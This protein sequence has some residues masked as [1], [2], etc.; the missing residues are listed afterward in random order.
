MTVTFTV[1]AA[2]L[3]AD[4]D[5]VV[6]PVRATVTDPNAPAGQQ[7]VTDELTITIMPPADTTPA[8]DVSF[9][10]DLALTTGMAVNL[11][12]PAATGGNG[13]L[14]YSLTPAIAGLTL[15]PT[16]RV[17]SGTP[18]SLAESTHT[19][20]VTDEDSDAASITFDLVVEMGAPPDTTPAF[21][22]SS[23]PDL[24]L[25][26]GTAVNMTLPAATG[27]NGALTYSLAPAIAGLTLNPTTRV[28]S[29]TPT[30]IAESTHTYTVTD[31]DSDTASL[32]FD[33]VV[34]MGG[35][36][37]VRPVFFQVASSTFNNYDEGG[38]A[39]GGPTTFFA[40]AGTETVVLTLTGADASFFSITQ[41]GALSFN[42]APDF[43]MPRG[44]APSGSNTNTYRVTVLA[45]A[46]PGGLT[47]GQ[48][49]EVRVVDVDEVVD[50]APSFSVTSIAAQNYLTGTAVNFTFPAA[51]GG[52]TPYTYTLTRSDG[53]AVDLPG[54]TFNAAANPPTLTGTPTA[55]RGLRGHF[56]TVH[57]SDANMA[58]GDRARLSFNIVVRAPTPTRLTL[59]IDPTMVT[60]SA[61][62]TTITATVTFVGG[63]YTRSRIV[64][65][66]LQDGTALEGPDFPPLPFT[67]LTIPANTASGTLMF[68]FTATADGIAEAGG[69][70]AKIFAALRDTSNAGYDGSLALVNANLTIN[71]PP[72]ID[73]APAFAAGAS[74]DDQSY[75]T[76]LAITPLTLPAVATPG[77]GATTYTL[78][79][80]IAGLTLN[81]TSRVL[82]GTPTTAATVREY[83]YTATDTDD[84][85]DTLTFNITVVA[86]TAPSFGTETITDQIFTV[87]TP[88][89]LTLPLATGGNNGITYSLTAPPTGLIFTPS[90]RALSGTPTAAFVATDLT[91]SAIDGD[92]NT[93]PSDRADITFSIT[94][95][96]P[97]V[98]ATGLTVTVRRNPGGV[99]T[100]ALEGSTTPTAVIATPTPAGSVFAADQ[101]V[102]FT[103]TPASPASRPDSPDDP[104]VA[105]NNIAPSTVAFAVGSAEARRT[106]SLRPTDDA[107]DHADFPLT[108][109]ATAQPSGISGT[110]TVTLIDN[111][112]RIITTAATATV[113]AAATTTYDVTLSEQ[114]PTGVAV[115]VASQGAGTATV[116]PATLTFTV[117]D[118]NMAQTVTVTGV[119]A[120]STTIRHTAPDASG[121][122]YV[123]NDVDVT[124]TAAPVAPVFTNADD[125][126]SPILTPENRAAVGADGYFAATGTGTVTYALTGADMARFTLSA[127]G[128]LTF[129]DAPDFE[130]P[131]GMAPATGNTNDYALTITATNSVGMTDATV[132]VS[133]TDVN[134]APVVATIT[135]SAFTEY[136]PGTF[137]ITVTDV[138]DGQTLTFALSAPNHGATLTGNTFT[139]TPGEDDG[140]V[141]RTFS[142]TVTDSGSPPQ[143]GHR[144]LR[145]HRNGTGE[146]RPDRRDH[147]RRRQ[148]HVGDQSGHP[149]PVRSRDRPR[150]RH[151]A[152]LHLEFGRHRR[153]LLPRHRHQHHLD[154]ADRHVRDPG[155]PDGHRERRRRHHADD[156]HGHAECDGESDV[157]GGHHPGPRRR[158]PPGL[159]RRPDGCVDP[160]G[161]HRRHRPLH[162]HPG[163]AGRLA[164][165][166]AHRR[167]Y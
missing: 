7:T 110:A 66:G 24:A 31:E 41:A 97:V 57:D 95:N 14:T 109:T 58:D 101:M 105:Y 5:N 56:Y 72:I 155:C 22:V 26:T 123:T 113:V 30:S 61:T 43:E 59:S 81:P 164:L 93:E 102:T 76:R 46:S 147:H 74:I 62:A 151:H 63:T 25:T 108:M 18:T 34:E 20:T 69:E 142:F 37:P 167:G 45:T 162:L 64:Q 48:A 36:A 94:A 38:T 99:I 87:G 136:T 122:G 90:T 131:R 52:N 89:D 119:A 49:V 158:I 127:A 40:E 134:E 130:M 140:G 129:N 17:L 39:V 23:T 137:D 152:D 166:P 75:L 149:R 50:T 55:V 154:T 141:A 88:V 116:S 44:M 1:T 28:L 106:F 19:Y 86:D 114:P 65:V 21:S 161:G 132:T 54:L 8:F 156:H 115:T 53:Q 160:A 3:L 133:V 29:G 126:D 67:T 42:P 16:T 143:D 11:T 163:R 47:Q 146:P 73:T 70:T 78:T 83:T 91:Y 32:V 145:H 15:N 112:I 104:Y 139:W 82:S 35:P 68:P 84:D 148:R 125:F 12:L 79:P 103:V 80:A 111:D 96:E 118:W 27:G 135:P 98:M 100:E 33:V 157:D 60:E 124:V 138:D 4:S 159:H 2:N 71:D 121:Y 165:A 144:H 92:A 153:Q 128:T 10:P 77:N 150:H 117:G 13:A 85:T 6:F 120:G 9:A 51:T 107:F